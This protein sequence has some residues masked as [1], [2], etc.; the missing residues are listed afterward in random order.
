MLFKK[1]LQLALGLFAITTVATDALAESCPSYE[2]VTAKLNKQYGEQIIFTGFTDSGSE[3]KATSVFEFWSNPERGSW[4]LVA[5]KL[6]LIQADGRQV[7]KDC[8]FVVKAGTQHQI[9]PAVAVDNQ[10][11]VA[12][13]A[14]TEVT[15]PLNRNCIPH[16]QHAKALRERYQEEPVLQAITSDKTLLEIYGGNA[17]WTIVQSQIKALTNPM[18][19]TAMRAPETGQEI[20]QMCSTALSAGTSWG[21]SEIEHDTI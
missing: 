1:P 8:A 16:S 17:S 19:G 20:H 18:T 12:D 6:V 5:H 21:T 9:L 3:R 10:P 11:E 4:S 15:E 13:S 14:E 7:S 2:E